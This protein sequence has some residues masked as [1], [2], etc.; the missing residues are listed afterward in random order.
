MTETIDQ[1]VGTLTDSF[2]DA[3]VASNVDLW[4]A[5]ATHPWV[6]SLADGTLPAEALTAW[7]QQCRLYCIQEGRALMVLRSFAPSEK[8]DRVLAQLVDDT[9][10]EP[11]E[12]E[13]TLES[14]GAPIVD[15]PWPICQGYSSFVNACAHQGL[16]EGVTAVYACERAYL[17][18]WTTVLPSVPPTL[19][20]AQLGRELE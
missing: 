3:L 13:D 2:T 7:A 1:S 4:H 5:M 8:L 18:T 9:V 10:R 16:V 12:L 17:D 15:E 19:R 11:R 14:L 20:V 6:R